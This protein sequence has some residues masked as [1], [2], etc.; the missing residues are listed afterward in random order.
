MHPQ[1][2]IDQLIARCPLPLLA[3]DAYS[4]WS[5]TDEEL[6]CWSVERLRPLMMGGGYWDVQEDYDAGFRPTETAALMRI[7]RMA[8]EFIHALDMLRHW[9]DQ[10][11]IDAAVEAAGWREIRRRSGQNPMI[12][13][14]D[15]LQRRMVR[16]VEI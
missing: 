3:K 14:Y 7:H 2:K 11:A 12:W 13:Q 10:E 8:V 9:R 5:A 4:P 15:P 16:Y 6:D 1:E